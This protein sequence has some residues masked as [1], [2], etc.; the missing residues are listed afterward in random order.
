MRN[1]RFAVFA[2]AGF[3]LMSC[4]ALPRPK[5][6]WSSKRRKPKWISVIPEKAGYYYYLGISQNQEDKGVALQK[7][8]EEGM[9]QVLSTI[10]IVV[11]TKMRLNKE[12][13]GNKEITKMVDKYRET[14]KAKLRGQKVKEMYTEEYLDG[15]RRFF[16]VYILMRYSE[17]EIK[18]ERRRI[19]DQQAKNRREADGKMEESDAMLKQGKVSSAFEEDARMF[20]MLA[21]Q[22]GISQYSALLNRIKKLLSS[23]ETETVV[24]K[25]KKPSVRL[26]AK[27]DGERKPV[28]GIRMLASFETGEGEVDSPK[29]TD[30]GGVAVFPISKIKFSGGIAKLKIKPMTEQFTVPLKN[31]YMDDSDFEFIEGILKG[32]EVSLILKASDFADT[33]FTLIVWNEKGKRETSFETALSKELTAAGISVRAFANVPQGVSFDSFE[34]DQFFSSLAAKGIDCLVA[35]SLNMIDNGDVYSLKSVTAE[36]HIKVIEIKSRKLLAAFEKSNTGVQI[37][38]KRAKAKTASS[39]VKDIAPKI[40][41]IAGVQ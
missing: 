16:D 35:G 15:D 30:E 22:P 37:N 26:V 19:E 31:A 25:G 1:K 14:G 40:V 24:S 27:I 2:F 11:G 13:S 7:A 41:D 4:S 6:V 34:N 17:K 20:T 39:L 38:F 29:T 3:F 10:G 21:D 8:L 33:K 18:K 36:A 9:K 23:L 28:S 12:I 5:K 32:L